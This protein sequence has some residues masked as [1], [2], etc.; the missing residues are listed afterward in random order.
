[1]KC[2]KFGMEWY[3]GSTVLAPKSMTIN[4]DGDRMSDNEFVGMTYT[5]ALLENFSEVDLRQAESALNKHINGL[6]AKNKRALDFEVE[7][8][9]VQDEMNRRAAME[10]AA[11]AWAKKNG[12]R[13]L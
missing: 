13:E 3:G 9:Y 11:A 12:I 5:R 10:A 1:M 4:F 2:V 8:C 6:R 7:L